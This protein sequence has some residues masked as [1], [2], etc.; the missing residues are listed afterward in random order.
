V[1]SECYLNAASHLGVLRTF[2]K[3]FDSGVVALA[4]V[5]ALSAAR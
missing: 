5:V 1:D 4:A 3:S 2:A